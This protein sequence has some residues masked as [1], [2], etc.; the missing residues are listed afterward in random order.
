[1]S[2][3]DPDSPYNRLSQALDFHFGQSIKNVHTAL[4]GIVSSYDRATK[5]AVVQPALNIRATSGQMIARAP[6]VDVPVIFPAGGSFII[7]FPLTAGD[8]VMLIVSERGLD[9]FKQGFVVSNP[10][11]RV[12]MRESDAVA[13]PGFGESTNQ[14]ADNDAL[15]IQTA[16]GETYISLKPD[17]IRVKAATITLE[18]DVTVDG[19]F[20]PP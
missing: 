9:Q 14:P 8:A 17:D 5:R 18:G 10:P 6:V 2:N 19:I 12:C 13:I 1:M 11:A 7:Q 16:D 3:R 20:T 4:P 15:T